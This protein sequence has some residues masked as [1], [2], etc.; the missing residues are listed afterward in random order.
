MGEWLPASGERI[1]N[2]PSYEIYRNTPMDT[3]KEKLR[4]DLYIPLQ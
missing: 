4:T 1:A 3:P 2:S